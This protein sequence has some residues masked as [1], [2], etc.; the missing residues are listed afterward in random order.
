MAAGH[1]TGGGPGRRL[2][3]GRGVSGLLPSGQLARRLN[4]SLG[5]A[6]GFGLSPCSTLAAGKR[7]CGHRGRTLV[8]AIPWGAPPPLRGWRR[9]ALRCD[10]GLGG[11]GLCWR[12]GL[13]RRGVGRLP[14]LRPGLRV[15]RR[16]LLGRRRRA[17]R[18]RDN[19]RDGSS[20]QHGLV[21]GHFHGVV[22]SW[23]RARRSLGFG[24]RGGAL[25]LARGFRC[26]LLRRRRRRLRWALRLGRWGLGGPLG[27]R[28][29]SW[30]G[31]RLGLCAGRWLGSLLCLCGRVYA[32]GPPRPR[33][34]GWLGNSLCL[35]RG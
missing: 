16:R 22:L 23:R 10:S 33:W 13:R 17:L 8:S 11:T 24:G 5:T 12:R 14:G 35:H 18:G 20:C 3:V 28:G 2:R 34:W 30:L 1:G 15:R 19:F 21:T 31:S 7:H 9:A 32:R 26:G 29:G 25:W 27:L 4:S 6:G